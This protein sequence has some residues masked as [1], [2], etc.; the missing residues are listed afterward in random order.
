MKKTV[1]V[2]LMLAMF[3]AICVPAKGVEE[4]KVETKKSGALMQA[5][6]PSKSI[7]ADASADKSKEASE[8][9]KTS[10]KGKQISKDETQDGKKK[11]EAEEVKKAAAQDKIKAVVQAAD[12]KDTKKALAKEV[13]EKKDEK[14]EGPAPS[15]KVKVEVTDV[16]KPKKPPVVHISPEQE[17]AA[18]EALKGP[19]T[20]E[21]STEKAEAGV[22]EPAAKKK[23]TLEDEIMPE[24]PEP[25]DAKKAVAEKEKIDL[26]LTPPECLPSELDTTG[27]DAG[28]N[29]VIKRA[30]WE[31][32]EK[33]YE[34][35]M[36]ANNSLYE[37]QVKFIKARG[38]IDKTAD[39]S[40]R[41]LGFEQ[42]QLTELLD[43]LIDDVKEERK[44]QGDLD[45]KERELLQTLK[46]KQRSLE[47]L[48]LNLKAVVE[49]EESLSKVMNNLNQQ[50]AV[51]RK[52]EKQA[53]DHFKA[54]GKELNDKKARLL[55]YEMEG[56][57]KTV[58]KN[59][60]YVTGALWNYFNDSAQQVKD[61]LD[62]IKT[63]IDALKTK[64]TD[65]AK[66]FERLEQ[67][68]KQKDEKEIEA[69][70]EQIQKELAEIA[71]KRKALEQGIWGQVKTLASKFFN[72]IKIGSTLAY[73][74]SVKAINQLVLSAKR[75]IGIK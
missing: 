58:E 7:V 65:L 53:W 37:Q 11:D 42:G 73:Q 9:K 59:R 25:G 61:N 52:Y 49:L 32:A 16:V 62:K 70:K 46:E 36:Q 40:L 38:A 39:A 35:I 60:D 74:S 19:K 15:S 26:D 71:Q 51:C 56:F 41:E 17:K 4:V 27:V 34:K 33:T 21:T 48:K 22:L 3:L 63:A 5:V 68:D 66:E 30:F 23:T 18:K 13:A 55:F 69:E 50:I 10:E 28:G 64:G 20:P 12:K 2:S 31:Q 6:K 57:L 72:S 29:W 44:Q 54:I 14:K 1:I 47:Q 45:E 43:S 75:L 67:A 8:E 24:A